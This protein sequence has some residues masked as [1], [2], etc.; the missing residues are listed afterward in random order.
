MCFEALCGTFSCLIRTSG[1][2]FFAFLALWGALRL[3]CNAWG[4]TLPPLVTYFCMFLRTWWDLGAQFVDLWAPFGHL[5]GPF[6][7]IFV[8]LWPILGL[9]SGFLETPRK[10]VKKE[11]KKGAEMDVFS[12]I[13]QV[14]PENGK[15]RFDCAGASGLR[16][17]PLIFWLRASIFAVRFLPRFFVFFGPSWGPRSTGTN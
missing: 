9:F 14:F 5:W 8:A 3:H 4:S 13:F 11:E 10:R 12:M 7:C 15:V 1:C 17:R 16:F 6:W 2:L